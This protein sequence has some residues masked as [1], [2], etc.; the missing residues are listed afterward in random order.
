MKTGVTMRYS[1]TVRENFIW[2]IEHDIPTCQLSIP[3]AL[4]TDEHIKNIR[5]L[6]AET[7]M[8]ITSLI[9]STTGPGTYNF[10]YGPVTLG[11]VPAAYRGQRFLDYMKNAETANALEVPYVNGHMGFIPENPGDPIYNEFLAVM[12]NLAAGFKRL[13]IGLN[14]ETGQETPVTLLRTFGDLQADNLGLNYDP[15]NLLMYGKANPIDGLDIVGSYVRSVHAKD[16]LYPTEGYA[17]GKETR[18][19]DGRVNFPAFIAKLKEIGY[20][21][22]LTIERE[23]SGEQQREDVLYANGVLLS[24]ING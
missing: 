15:A 13:G 22:A 7:G 6:C 19:G 24:L 8:E 2:C 14:F 5:A 17:L 1:D 23:I 4:Q 3:L 21:G 9:G 18:L 10:R 16:G 11:M 12:H 20:D